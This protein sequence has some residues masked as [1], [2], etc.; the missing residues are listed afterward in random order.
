MHSSDFLLRD[1]HGLELAIKRHC[2]RLSLD[3]SN[4]H[5]VRQFVSEMLQNMEKLKNAASRGDR[6]ARTKVELFGM[7]LLMQKAN[8]KAFG[9][10][11]MSHL[12]VL[13]EH[14]SAW[15]AIARVLW[16]ELASRNLDSE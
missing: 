3:C 11:Y 2:V 16:S 4:D 15:V 10:E 1:A 8:A 6:L 9:P 14:Q 7:T 12:D 5:Q 13:E